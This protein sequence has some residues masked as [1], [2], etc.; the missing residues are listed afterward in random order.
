MALT[1]PQRFALRAQ[2][3][4]KFSERRELL[5]LTKPELAATIIA[6]D[7][8]IE[9]NSTEFNAALP[10]VARNTLTPLQKAEL[11]AIVALARFN[12]G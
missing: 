6:V 1:D 5:N 4:Q 3:G 11:F 12:H 8:W 9:A 10:V 2:I 7:A